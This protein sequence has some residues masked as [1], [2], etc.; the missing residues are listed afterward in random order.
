MEDLELPRELGIRFIFPN[1]PEIAVTA[2][3]GYIMPAWYD[4]LMLT[5]ERVIN[6]EQLFKSVENIQQLLDREIA[7]GI[8]SDNIMLIGFSQGGAVAYHAALSYPDTLAAVVGLS[9]YLPKADKLEVQAANKGLAALVCHGTQ[10]HMV[11]E[12]QGKK[13]AYTLQERGHP[14]EYRC[15]PMAHEVCLDEIKE[16]SRFIQTQLS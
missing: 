2:N 6:Q 1:A 5:E 10:D 12:R 11:V 8:S 7:R 15:Y 14:V 9:T 4:I 3:A 16:I 13:A